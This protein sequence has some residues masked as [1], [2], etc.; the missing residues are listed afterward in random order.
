M[1]ILYRTAKFKSRQ[2]YVSNGDLG[3]NCQIYFPPIVPAIRYLSSDLA[4][5]N[6]CYDAS[7][8]AYIIAYGE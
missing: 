5:S 4:T 7:S 3:P 2:Y 1:V 8:A 6:N